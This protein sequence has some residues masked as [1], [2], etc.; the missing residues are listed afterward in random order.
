MALRDEWRAA[1]QDIAAP[2]SE[3]FHCYDDRAAEEKGYWY[4]T[5]F[6][7]GGGTVLFM[8]LNDKS[9]TEALR[10][11]II[12]EAESEST[13]TACGWDGKVISF[14]FDGGEGSMEMYNRVQNAFPDCQFPVG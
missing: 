11:A 12:M 2:E 10:D 7:Q 6:I 9:Q 13:F 4:S 14:P 3:G 1:N 5:C 8:V